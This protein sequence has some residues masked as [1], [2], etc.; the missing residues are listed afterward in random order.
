MVGGV[1]WTLT[2]QLHDLDYAHDKCHLS[3][4]LQNMQ[5]KS[6]HP[7]L[8]AEK[9]GLRISKEKTEVMRASSKQR[10]KIKLKHEEL[11]DVQSFTYLGSVVTLDG[12]A[13]EDIKSRIGKARQAF[14]P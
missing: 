6:D 4:K 11:E 7:A 8:G 3:E 5:I 2:T 12:R 9:T 10:E 14:K 1:Q 13:D